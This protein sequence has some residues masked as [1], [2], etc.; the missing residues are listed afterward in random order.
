M[1]PMIR[2]L[3]HWLGL[4]HARRSPGLLALSL[5]GIA[6]GVSVFVAIQV[7]NRTVLRTFAAT[8]DAVAGR[9]TLEIAAGPGGIPDSLFVAV[10]RSPGIT[11]ATPLVLGHA[12]LPTR[13]G[14]VAE[15][16]G[17][18]PIS[19]R[20]F[21][22]Y[23]AASTG[24]SAGARDFLRLLADPR[25]ALIPE[26]MARDLDLAPGDRLPILIRSAP[27]TVTIAGL[28]HFTGAIER[29][30][31]RLLVLDI[32]AAQEV[33]GKVGRIDRIDLLAPNP[34]S[35]AAALRALPVPNGL[36][37][38]AVVRRP[39]ARSAQIA[40]LLAAFRL[41][42]TALSLIALFVGTFL[43]YNAA[44]TSVVRRRREIGVLRALGMSRGAVQALVLSEQLAL[45]AIGIAAGLGLGLLLAREMLGAIAH[46]VSALYVRVFVREL[47]IE[48]HV[49]LLAI[50]AGMGA[51]VVAAWFPARE[52]ANLVPQT[53]LTE[54]RRPSTARFRSGRMLVAGAIAWAL[55]LAV[56]RVQFIARYPQ[57]GFLAAL[58]ILVG[59]A[60]LAPATAR[61]LLVLVRPAARRWPSFRLAA[62]EVRTGLRRAAVAIAALG[63]ALAMVIAIS[64]MITSF[65][66]TVDLW[67]EQTVR[68]DLYVSPASFEVASGAAALDPE[69]I[70]AA[71]SLPGV[72]AVDRLR[73]IDGLTVEGQAVRAS[74][75]IF[76]VIAQESKFWFLAVD[77]A[78]HGASASDVLHAAARS[79]AVVV[80]EP[81]ARRHR[82]TAGDSLRLATPS[83][84]RGFR[85]AG[86][87][88]DYS[89]D[90]GLVLIDLPAYVRAFGDSTTNSL[91]L[92]LEDPAAGPALRSQLL[93]ATR[94]HALVVRSNRD[95][96]QAALTEFDRTFAV[97]MTL[98]L[99]TV[100]TAI[101]GVFFTLTVSVAERRGEIGV[102]RAL[103]A[104]T[105]QVRR[106]VLGE[107]LLIGLAALAIGTA[108]GIA[109]A[110]LLVFVVNPMFFGWTILWV[111]SPRVFLEAVAVVGGAS[112]LAAWWPARAATRGAP[113]RSFRAE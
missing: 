35:A 83:G 40:T 20:P 90:A 22:A 106:M 107:A 38:D 98:K 29:T 46:T 94:G 93:A 19:N 85:I 74:A 27:D 58:L 71:T 39:S 59:G 51:V 113:A 18:D 12:L 5:A 36:P 108:T 3:L 50:A 14:E 63:S 33:S 17:V 79:G 64:I 111:L 80:S 32:A 110:R 102:L 95:L 54:G 7:A 92:Y 77:P 25:A 11:A 55:A 57:T 8:V 43:V 101:A 21:A 49:L 56:T 4:R 103:G 15:L 109:L 100:I 44:L 97:T 10:R 26:R 48:P 69:V 91:A 76:D 78:L 42:L 88:R 84:P 99:I 31:E 2:R 60:L 61:A 65:R 41:N 112:L 53:V 34:D 52:A 24:D 13:P 81:L 16:V 87:F 1:S 86:V 82:L 73:R 96:R 89:S 105:G 62:G 45:G 72:R 47:F 28:L 66:R 68:A 70:R 104:S 30:A 37:A 67:V 6:L 9:A 23:A 75:I